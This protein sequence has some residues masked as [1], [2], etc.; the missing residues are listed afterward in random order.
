MDWEIASAFLTSRVAGSLGIVVL[1]LLL[2]GAV[3][4]LRW[5]VS[6]RLRSSESESLKRRAAIRFLDDIYVVALLMILVGALYLALANLSLWAA[7][8]QRPAVWLGAVV[9]GLV[10]I[11][12]VRMTRSFV[13]V[14]TEHLE[15]RLQTPE[16]LR[17][18][19]S[20][21]PQVQQVEQVTLEVANRLV[22]DTPG[23]ATDFEPIMRYTAFAD[24]NINYVVIM[25]AKDWL[26][27]R[28]LQH[29]FI[30]AVKQRY[31]EVGIEISFPARNLYLRESDGLTALAATENAERTE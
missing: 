21:V 13:S 12:A 27:S 31:D 7:G 4:W 6:R 29:R 25:R 1:A 30:K 3:W 22:R 14:F 10:L 15:Q 24:S 11:A 28:L 26:T 19:Q 5:V 8:D 23:A 17:V 20:I 18:L 9:L 16:Q 2:A